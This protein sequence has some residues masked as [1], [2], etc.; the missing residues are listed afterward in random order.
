[1]KC[2]CG[3][4]ITPSEPAASCAIVPKNS[5]LPGSGAIW[6]PSVSFVNCI[7]RGMYIAYVAT[8]SLLG[9]LIRLIEQWLSMSDW[10][11]IPWC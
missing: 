3:C 4:M 8:E 6:R 10:N 5:G 11:G 1:M 2:R 7:C 9:F